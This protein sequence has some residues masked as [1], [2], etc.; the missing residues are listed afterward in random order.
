MKKLAVYLSEDLYHQL[1]QRAAQQGASVEE[2]V[3]F[4]VT[5]TYLRP[6][7]PPVAATP[8][9]APTEDA[10][11][12]KAK[13]PV[14]PKTKVRPRRPVPTPLLPS[15]PPQPTTPREPVPDELYVRH[16]TVDE[17]IYRLE[18]YLDAA[19]LAGHILV[20]VVH[21]K[22]GGILKRAIWQRLKEHPLVRSYRLA[23]VGDG[24]AGVTVVELARR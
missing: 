9:P 13:P 2:L 1:A 5:Q 17:A 7:A 20:R 4:A 14:A 11:Q 18:A 12:P 21:G 22:G 8:S 16:Q 15:V 10:P 23:Q 3:R 19:F 6:P 24:D